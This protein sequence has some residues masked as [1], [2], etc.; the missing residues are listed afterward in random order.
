MSEHVGEVDLPVPAPSLS[1]EKVRGLVYL[2][3]SLWVDLGM[4]LA[5]VD[6]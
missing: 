6:L 3:G 1:S 2:E 4:C 5:G